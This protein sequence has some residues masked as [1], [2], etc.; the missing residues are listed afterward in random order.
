MDA[1]VSRVVS[2]FGELAAMD[3]E[4]AIEDHLLVTPK[5]DSALL[6]H[7]DVQALLARGLRSSSVAIRSFCLSKALT[8]IEASSFSD[9]LWLSVLELV[10]DEDV[11]VSQRAI[12]L[13]AQHASV[14]RLAGEPLQALDRLEQESVMGLLRV[15]ELAMRALVAN[16][17]LA[18][19]PYIVRH[20]ERLF[21]LSVDAN[22]DLLTQMSA[23]ELVSGELIGCDWGRNAV[24]DASLI[25]KAVSRAQNSDISL[26]P[27]LLR[28]VGL[29]VSACGDRGLEQLQKTA[30]IHMIASA[31]DDPSRIPEL[32]LDASLC[33]AEGICKSCDAGRLL[34]CTSRL[35]ASVVDHVRSGDVYVR[36]R[37]SHCVADVLATLDGPVGPEA[38]TLVIKTIEEAGSNVLVAKLLHL[39]SQPLLTEQRTAVF[40]LLS[41]LI[42]HLPDYSFHSC[43]T[44]FA[45]I[46][47]R[48]S[49][50]QKDALEW[51]YIMVQSA[52]ASKELFTDSQISILKTY[53]HQGALYKEHRAEVKSDAN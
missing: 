19:V 24:L 48:S 10:R 5:L 34:L 51:K 21:S 41:M 47:N 4:I 9:S 18:M 50:P 44:L 38:R 17:E 11:G 12:A 27:A 32:M 53:L 28:F 3:S 30:A 29:A 1:S 25:E 39:A 7:P 14:A 45:F 46:T 2:Y 42:K 31:L 40:R 49:D 43:P 6:G 26:S 52:F 35:L 37:S 16:K 36:I 23:L 15:L 13:A 8:K 22:V 33:V 20:L